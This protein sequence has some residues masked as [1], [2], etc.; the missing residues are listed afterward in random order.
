VII[1]NFEDT[2]KKIQ[3][4]L[5][6]YLEKK[7]LDTNKNFSCINP[8]HTDGK[9]SMSLVRPD[10]IRF[11]CHGCG[12]TGDIFDAAYMLENK[13]LSGD[14]YVSE[15]LI[16]LA[17]EFE[18][19]I[20]H[21]ELT[22]DQ[23][24]QLDTYKAYRYAF[25]YS[26]NWTSDSLP[27]EI[28][29][30][31]ERRHWDKKSFEQLREL[32]VGFITDSSEY[33]KHMKGLGFSAKFIDD[34]DLGRKDIFSPGHLIFTIK[35]E[36][37]RPVGFAAR[38][39]GEEGPKYVNQKTTG[40][41]C[42]IYQKGKRLYGLDKALKERHEGPLYI[43]EGYSDVVSCQINGFNR[44]V[45][46]CGTALTDDH[47][48]LLKENGIYDIILCLDADE[49]GQT[50]TEVLL[51][52][53]FVKH[54][55]INVK[56]IVLPNDDD[57]DEFIRDHGIEAFKAIGPSTAF[58]WRLNRFEEEAD[59]ED[60]CKKMI[61]LVVSEPSHIS[62]EKMLFDLVRHT[63]FSIKT[64]QSELHRLINDKDAAKHKERQF[65]IDKTINDLQRSPVEAE[66]ILNET[67]GKLYS[68]SASYDQDNFS[69]EGTLRFIQDLKEREQEKD[70]Q[71]QGFVLG[72][73]L[74]EL[75][76]LVLSGDWKK[77]VMMVVGG[78]ANTGKTSLMCKLAHAIA[79][80]EENNAC[81]IYHTID[82]T[83]EQV[84]PKFV[85]ITDGSTE[86]QINEVKNPKFFR[87]HEGDA[88]GDEIQYRREGAYSGLISLCRKGRLVLKDAND[89]MSLGYAESLIKYYQDK[90]PDRQ[91]VYIL[92][93][94]HKLRDFEQMGD[95]R[96][97]FKIMSTV[98]KNMAT[99]FH[100]PVLCT[101][102]YTKLPAG[103]RPTNDNIS[104]CLTGDTRIF[105]YDT[106][107]YVRLDSVKPGMKTLTLNTSA[108][109]LVPSTITH[110]LDKGVQN[111]YRVTLKSGRYVDTTMNHPFFS[112]DG[113][114]KLSNLE[115]GSWIGI[116]DYIPGPYGCGSH[117]YNKKNNDLARL[118]GYLAG[119]GS[120]CN[121]QTPKFT[122]SENVYADDVIE[123]SEKYF[124]IKTTESLNKGSRE[125][126]L[127]KEKDTNQ[128][129]ELTAYLEE[130]G[131]YGEKKA[132]KSI[133]SVIWKAN[134]IAIGHYLAGLFASD[135]S[136]Q[137][138]PRRITFSNISENLVYGTQSLLLRLGIHSTVTKETK[139]N[140]LRLSVN[141][142]CFKRF[143]H[144]IPIKGSKKTAL[145]AGIKDSDRLS[146]FGVLPPSYTELF[147]E[148][149]KLDGNNVRY[150][151]GYW[152]QKNTLPKQKAFDIYP[153]HILNKDELAKIID[154]GV[155]WDQIK[156]IEHMG[157]QHVWDLTVEG[158]HNFVA[159]D[160][161][162]HNTV[163]M[164]YDANLICHLYN[165]MHEKG[166]RA[167]EHTYHQVVERG[168]PTRRPIIEMIV[169]KNKIGSFKS[170][171]Y[172]KFHPPS[173]DFKPHPLDVALAGREMSNSSNS[174]GRRDNLPANGF[175]S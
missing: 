22:E 2:T 154:S 175:Y 50:K 95:E 15:T 166:D 144:S 118:L 107:E 21:T 137:S 28:V 156:S 171:I 139:T 157:D 73:D 27:E 62:Q 18:V 131:I 23:L 146:H 113:W 98:V 11:F 49:A 87:E 74:H 97:R 52:T 91:V 158:T 99:R 71:Y 84:L 102:E 168:G 110:L 65:I 117:H 64:L 55:D 53:R 54:K 128:K 101:M 26:C 120:Y 6:D 134:D 68:L 163:Q 152:I 36:Y 66:S 136:I 148:S 153:E 85:C 82:D 69:E 162:C 155:Y 77:D 20:E 127:S 63:G 122:N 143:E 121:N 4:F 29:K 124:L 3:K 13:P 169:G 112:E 14:G 60:M 38:N 58:Q 174:N 17:K 173:S 88:V 165:E 130:I 89:G 75:Q 42:N 135:G 167:E 92:D 170:S 103:T 8:K 31:F 33:R 41:K 123:I 106:K 43:F 80:N 37:G 86:L 116:P 109:K 149:R 140:M 12:C 10:N 100:I 30:E 141:N 24:Y 159:N 72:E 133:P 125:I 172:F 46:A 1:K 138:N 142:E 19:K 32:G 94:F 78:K 81:V 40:V 111:T 96:T 35:D 76:E 104:E 115:V 34:V 132:N 48:F 70:G 67:G 161:L 57:P 45:A 147:K 105:N 83:K 51:D 93:N 160:I 151:N 164:E 9:P 108:Q 7:G 79:S 39:L 119:D 47:L 16:Y 126:S 129:N 44:C 90:Y 114:T 5:P 59:A 61:P 145:I 56:V 25:D 150:N